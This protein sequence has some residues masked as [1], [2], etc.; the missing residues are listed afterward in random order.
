MD[1]SELVF[2]LSAD[3]LY[4]DPCFSSGDLNFFDDLD[5]RLLLK[6][7]GHQH[8]HHHVPSAEE[9]LEEET[10]V[11]EHVRAPGGLHQAGRCL[12]WACKACKRKTTHADRRKAA[13]MR[14]RRRLSKVND[15]FETLKR[16]TASNPNQRLAKVEILRNAISYIESLQALL[17]TSGQDQSFYPPLEPYGADSEASSPQSNCSDGAM[18]YVSPCVTSNAKNNRSRRNIQTTGDSSS[19]QCLV[20]SLECLSSIVERISTDPT[21]VAPVGDSV[22]PRGPGSPQSSPAGIYEPL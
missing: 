11:E 7:E 2:P 1:L 18:D 17:R 16:C 12:L 6:P 8:L 9:E 3:D 22:V 19:K 14:E 15:A 10:V 5:S 20:S 4:D 21:V 13:T